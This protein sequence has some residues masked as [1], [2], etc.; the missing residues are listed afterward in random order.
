MFRAS[1]RLVLAYGVVPRCLAVVVA[2][3][4]ATGFAAPGGQATE[5]STSGTPRTTDR[6]ERARTTATTT[7]RFGPPAGTP[8][9]A[10]GPLGQGVTWSVTADRVGCFFTQIHVG[11]T[12]GG[13]RACADPPT[14]PKHL[15]YTVQWSAG[16]PVQV[17]FI[18]ARRGTTEIR[19]V[20]RSRSG[21]RSS[22]LARPATAAH[23]GYVVF[24]VPI[25]LNNR[26]VAA[27][28]YKSSPTT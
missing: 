7:P 19:V 2:V 25:P 23:H 12:I 15:P 1:C 6:P 8:A 16:S 10:T 21:V 26:G 14:D 18:V 28:T 17:A 5:L 9:L 22:S 24:V 11:E 4:A 27:S 13:S 20:S 3:V